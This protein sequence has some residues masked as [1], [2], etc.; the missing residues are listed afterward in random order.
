MSSLVGGPAVSE[1]VAGATL[2][3]GVVSV[4]FGGGRTAAFQELALRDACPCADCRHPVS[5]QRLFESHRVLP[6]TAAEA[7]A[8]EPDGALAVAWSDGHGS[9]YPAGWLV[10]EAEAA[11][12]GRPPVQAQRLWDASLRDEL[13]RHDWAAASTDDDACAAWLADVASLGFGVLRGVPREEGFVEH[14][15]RLFGSVRETNYGRVFDV[16][17]RVGATNLAD[18]ALPLSPHTDNPYRDPTPTLQLLHCLE[19]EVAGGDTVLV[20]GF[21]AVTTLRRESPERLDVLARIPIRYAY[22]DGSADLAADVPVVSVDAAGRPAA[23]HVNN[24][25]KGVPVGAPGLVAAWYDAYFELLRL[26]EEPAAQLVFRLEPG[27][28]VAFDNVRVL[29]GRTGFASEGSRRLQGCYADRDGLLSRLAVL[30]RRPEG[31]H[32]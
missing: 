31:D 25:S 2:A 3:G 19:S 18:T 7:V 11:V 5:G 10:R 1:P 30:Q 22:R 20:D 12:R 15:A 8:V 17:V 13:R 27:D 21:Q 28:L 29:H 16:S 32:A 23:L 9:S 4:A 26:I 6:G 14:A 24:R